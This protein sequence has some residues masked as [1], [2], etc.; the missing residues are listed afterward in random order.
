MPTAQ[1]SSLI[2]YQELLAKTEPQRTDIVKYLREELPELWRSEYLSMSTR[3]S[4]IYVVPH[5]TFD[6][7]FDT[8]QQ[9]EDY[10]PQS[11]VLPVEARLV[12]AIGLS[13]PKSTAR[14]DARLR[15]WPIDPSEADGGPWD[16][17]HYIAH[18]I[19]GTVDG[20]EANVF[21]QLRAINRGPYRKMESYCRANPGVLCFSRP[22]YVDVT[23]RPA[24]VEFGVLKQDGELWVDVFSNR[25]GF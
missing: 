9:E 21:R 4:E 23:S 13:K 15:G 11:G 1:P 18:S 19:G 17:G 5:G 12:A 16:R 6:Y 14:D 22:I 10:D 7:L 8:Y 25:D 24:Q 3:L 2:P 20:N